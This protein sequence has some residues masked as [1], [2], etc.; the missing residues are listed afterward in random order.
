MALPEGFEGKSRDEIEEWFL[1][2]GEEETP[3]LGRMLDL[4]EA[5]GQVMVGTRQTAGPNCFRT[6]SRQE[7]MLCL[8]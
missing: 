1:T 3:P 8:H 6:A 2:A 5:M 4:L 7:K